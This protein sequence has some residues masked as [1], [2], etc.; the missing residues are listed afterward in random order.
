MVKYPVQAECAKTVGQ[1]KRQ[2]TLIL[3]AYATQPITLLHQEMH[4][5]VTQ[6]ITL[7]LLETDAHATLDSMNTIMGV[8]PMILITAV[9]M[10]RIVK[11]RE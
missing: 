8:K 10:I 6:P 1:E 7:L 3:N 9:H 2:I 11:Y 5:Y 4:V